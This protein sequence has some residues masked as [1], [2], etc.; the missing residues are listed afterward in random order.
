[1]PKRIVFYFIGFVV[2]ASLAFYGFS[3]WK[4]SREKVDLWT[5]VP[6]SAVLVV[7]TNDHLALVEHLRETGLWESLSTLPATQ[8][9]QE[10]IAYLD[11]VAPGSQR[12]ERFLDKKEILTSVHVVGNKDVEVVY[13][14]PVNTVGEHR[15]LRTLTEDIGKSPFFD[16][17]THEYQDFLITDVRN[18]YTGSTFSYF[19]YHNNI[20]LSPSPAL[21]EETVRRI[22]RRTP[23][24]VAAE[25]ASTNYLGQ[26][27]VYANVFVN[28][29]A[30]PDLLALFLEAEIMPEVRYLA[31]LCRSGMLELKLQQDKIFLNGFSL[32]E[33]LK[34]SL[35][36]VMQPEEPRELGVKNYLP[37]RTALLLH[38]GLKE[39]ERLRL[40]LQ[41]A[42]VAFAPAVDSLAQTFSS[43]AAIAYLETNSLTASPEKVAYAHMPAPALT[44]QL[45]SSLNRQVAVARKQQPYT[46]RYGSYDIML[47]QIPE[48]PAQLF[49]RL[50]Q[51]FEQSY[52]VQ[53]DNYLLIAEEMATLRSLLDDI[54]DE[55]VWGKSGGQKAFLE[56]TLQEANLSVYF[57]TVNAWYILNRYVVEENREDLLQNASLI[58]RFSQLSLQFSLVDG[59]YYTS[60]VIRRPHLTNN[61]TQETFA[62]EQTLP[63]SNRI[64]TRPFPVQNTVDRSPEVIVQDSADV[65]INI[66]AS[67]QRG[68]V[69]TLG[70]SIRGRIKQI[71]YG[72]NNKLSYVFATANRIHAINNQ[73]QE[74][75]NFPFNLGDSLDIQHLVVFDYENNKEYRLLVDDSKG[76]LYMYNMSGAAIPGWQP[77][78][79]DYKLAAEPQHLRVGGTDV[80][81]VPLEN[82]YVYALNPEGETLPGFPISL[83]SPLTSGVVVNV[84]ADLKQ[85]ELTAVTRYGNVVTFNLQG[86]VLNREQLPRP[87]KRALF[88]L[89]PESSGGRSFVIVRQEQGQVTIF[90]QDLNQLFE[91]RYVTSAPKIVQY[92]NFGGANEI[93]A[94][95]E[96]GPQKTYLYDTEGNLIGNRTFESNKPVSIYYNETTNTYTLYKVFRNELKKISFTLPD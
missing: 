20:I 93:F 30:L 74:L 44:L 16:E 68:W 96:T 75:E 35:H 76:N 25:F 33:K 57:N 79:L 31:S 39:I 8:L 9:L 2:L 3:R 10:N 71:E 67:G 41:V 90:D 17:G 70:T 22:N 88:E 84:G 72:P 63:L 12:L 5:L 29:R 18:T 6:D 43:E 19:T 34:T 32:P 23:A 15:F 66:T 95:T 36:S 65:L 50:F 94:V 26:P 27:D 38:F 60:L 87:S 1:M 54:S 69:D 24:S 82:G 73:G 59:Q 80:I 81:L 56:E 62:V 78:K 83:K 45:L 42:D 89:V 40:P 11:S 47:L 58:K 7:E 85:T 77:R 37:N 21:L 86:R 13:Y 64:D 48:L 28:Y 91:K 4:D 49:G 55:D 52:V 46:E 92:F 61:V 51:G 53:V 14:I